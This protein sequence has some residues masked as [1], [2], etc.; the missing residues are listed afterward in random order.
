M[1]TG[2]QVF[3]IIV[4]AFILIFFLLPVV[5]LEAIRSIYAGFVK[6]LLFI[7][8]VVALYG[9]IFANDWTM[10]K[11]VFLIFV[12][13]AFIEMAATMSN[14]SSSSHVRWARRSSEE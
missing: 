4:V 13:V 1:L 10:F 6:V 5:F 14:V 11:I 2:S 3:W 8:G 9:L 12:L 7:L